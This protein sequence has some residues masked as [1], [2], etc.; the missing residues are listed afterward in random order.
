M[1]GGAHVL[2]KY[3]H[4]KPSPKYRLYAQK[5]FLAATVV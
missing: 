2:K 4:D 5:F 3:L 1:I